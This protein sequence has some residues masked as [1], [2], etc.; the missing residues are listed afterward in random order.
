MRAR[1][2]ALVVW[3]AFLGLATVIVVR[4]RY[5]ADL[6]AFLPQAPSAAQRLLVD[7]LR[8]GP[9]SRLILVAIEAPE[10]PSRGYLSRAL[11]AR[12]RNDPQFQTVTN[13][14]ASGL[15]RDREFVFAHRYLLSDRV[16]P[17][18]FS[19]LGLHSAIEESIE[20]LAT[21]VG[22][23]TKNLLVRDPT[24]E[25]LQVL[26]QWD[27]VAPPATNAGVWASTDGRR[28]LLVA[29]TRAA[30]SDTDGQQRAVIAIRKAFSAVQSAAANLN[31]GTAPTTAQLR[32]SGPGVFAVAARA[33]IEREAIRF[34]MLS[35][36]F[37]AVFLL[38]VYRSMPAL[39]LGLL[40]VASGALAG[41]AA[42][43]M[44]FGV[45]HAVTL[46]FGVTLIGEAVDYSVYL[47]LQ[48]RRGPH[49]E[50]ASTA[51]PGTLWPT[52]WL[53]MLT[54]V[55]G[56]ASLLP[57]DFPG[58]AQLGCYS[59][60]GLVTA[61]LVTRFVLPRLLPRDLALRTVAPL[62]LAFAKALT[63]LR[64]WR[65]ALWLVAA[66]AALI[67]YT[68]RDHLWHRELS[69]LSPV[70]A[71]DQSLDAELRADLGA[72]DVRT[73]VIVS[74]V[75]PEAVLQSAEVVSRKL[76]TLVASGDI[77]NFQTPT[78][79]LPSRATQAARRDSIPNAHALP[80]LLARSVLG[81]PIRAERLAA[82]LKDVE[83]TRTAP[84]LT[85]T[86]LQRT[87][88]APVFDAMMI[89]HGERWSAL[90]PLESS[91][92]GQHAFTIDIERIKRAVR[93]STAN[94]V[95]VVV[96]DLKGESDALYTGYLSEAVRLSLAGLAAIV[97]VLLM[98][99]R[100][101]W[102]VARVVAPLL[103]AVLVVIAGFAL[104][105]HRLTLLHLI[106]M[107]LIVA[108]GSNYALFFDRRP[109]ALESAADPEAQ[110]R[111][112]ASLLVANFTTVLAFGTLSLSTVPV[113]SAL[114]TTVAPGTL[115]ALLFAAIM[116]KRH[117]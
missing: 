108:I 117:A 106:G 23:L 34:S 72:P 11:A 61:A 84:L 65:K 24:G 95:E 64:P 70:S 62:G 26:A 77:A 6:S 116:A 41:V 97:L 57:S 58:L 9:A 112:I 79:Y 101:P 87:S 81:L 75:D 29:Q 43:A 28:A 86:D 68:D 51:V 53:G 16:T 37:I 56:F 110:T 4:A 32:L 14:D 111:T 69:A 66:A 12:L 35:S 27:P 99:L 60:A 44:T 71:A 73:L 82:F 21:P 90:L 109:S 98:V 2:F 52:I 114:G 55:C 31:P 102:R 3:I 39:M 100:S 7:Q 105:G 83:A 54:S 15:E 115:L 76:D 1:A 18:H 50:R 49:G 30:G 67:V 92:S 88:I 113:L 19:A 80:A 20:Q 42:V 22:S 85:R 89:R 33:R 38:A 74:A 78:R 45:V 40:P 47:F 46:G 36:L 25:T 13:G 96:L 104:I 8:E 17:E 103:L 93:A 63:A 10:D 91:A 59:I 107:L 94:D 48:A 5:T